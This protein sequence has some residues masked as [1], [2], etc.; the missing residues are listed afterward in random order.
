MLCLSAKLITIFIENPIIFIG[1]SLSDSNIK[2]IL[3]SIIGCLDSNDLEKLQQRLYFVEYTES[4]KVSIEP[5]TYSLQSS[6]SPLRMTNIKIN[7]F[8]LLFSAFE[9]FKPRFPVKKLRMLKAAFVEF[10]V[11]NDPS[12]KIKVGNIDNNDISDYDLGLYIGKTPEIDSLGYKGIKRDEIFRDII[13]DTQNFDPKRL[14]TE[15]FPDCS[16]ASSGSELPIYKYLQKLNFDT[17]IIPENVNY[18]K[19]YD[20]LITPSTIKKRDR[21]SNPE[22]RSINKIIQYCPPGNYSSDKNPELA[23]IR[24]QCRLM[25]YLFADEIDCIE[26]G[27]Y[28]IDILNRYPNLFNLTNEY[29]PLKNYFRKM[30]RIYDYLKYSKKSHE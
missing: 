3:A 16:K 19:C 28:L 12:E 10:I 27:D 9:S 6:E 15:T 24:T 13:L 7:D 2:E 30:I 14:I 23:A 22:H 1:Y 8:K 11:T 18:G 5:Q 26:L 17:S 20:D 29:Y 4:K 25:E 21:N